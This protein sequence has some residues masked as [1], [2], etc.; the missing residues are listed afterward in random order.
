MKPALCYNYPVYGGD[1]DDY[2]IRFAL[3]YAAFPPEIEHDTFIICN[4]GKL[5]SRMQNIIECIGTFPN[6]RYIERESNDGQDIGGYQYAS[7]FL[8]Y[9]AVM[10]FGGPSHFKRAG[11]FKRIME[12]WDRQG[13]SM[14]GTMASFLQRPHLQTTGFLTAPEF[15]RKWGKPVTT[16]K[17]RYNFEWGWGALWR[18]VVTW[19]MPA[20]LVTWDGEYAPKDW[21]KPAN[22]LWRGDQSNCLTYFRHSDTYD[23]ASVQERQR[24]SRLADGLENDKPEQIRS[25]QEIEL[26][27]R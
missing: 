27:S 20:M 18:K 23:D 10:Y 14:L 2:A 11:W 25:R 4:G 19:K 12:V 8:D 21:R 26:A 16:R 3:S 9:P 17:E 15:I 6:P 5:N 7:M 1:H 13:P 24:L 22:C